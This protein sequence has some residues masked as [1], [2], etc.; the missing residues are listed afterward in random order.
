MASKKVY[1]GLYATLVISVLWASA[2]PA[3]G[4]RLE[5]LGL[6]PVGAER[7][8][9]KAGTIPP[10]NGGITEPIPGY[11]EG[12][13]HPNPF[14]DDPILFTISAENMDRYAEQLSEGQQALL[15]A[16]PKSWF[17]QIYPTRRSAAYPEFVYEALAR[18]IGSAMLVTG[19]FDG[20]S[21]AEISSPFP[22]PRNGAQVM[23]NHAMRWHGSYIERFENRAAVTRFLGSYRRLV[24]LEQGAYPY[25]FPGT[26]R[27]KERFPGLLVAGRQKIVAPAALAGNAQL[28]LESYNYNEQPRRIWA[29][30][31]DLRKTFATPFA[32]YDS[33]APNTDSLRTYDEYDL[34]NGPLVRFEWTLLGKREMYIPYNAYRLHS[35][36]VTHQRILKKRHIDPKL[37]RYELHRVWVVEGRVKSL[38]RNPVARDPAERGHIYSRRVFYID[39][40]TWQVAMSDN[41]D[42]QGRLWR[43]REGHMMNYYEV[44]APWYTLKVFY[45]LRARRYLAEGLD[46]DFPPIKFMEE[47]NPLLFSPTAL[48]FF[49]R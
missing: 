28:V 24:V 43:V 36:D 39:E 22:L 29:Y 20:V 8:G 15:R 3:Q 6:T 26:S 16:H 27:L 17:M 44:P 13:R 49:V 5:E 40:D 42:K 12:Q 48:D 32:G 35:G 46:N 10:W 25:A 47:G 31:P 4:S 30:S 11:Q 38:T 41:Y 23:W 21:G 37:A 7:A 33:P 2:T 1:Y 45:D 9:N 19:R 18:N 34:W 14:A